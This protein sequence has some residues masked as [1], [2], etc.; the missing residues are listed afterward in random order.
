MQLCGAWY[1]YDVPQTSP[2]IDIL[3]IQTDREQRRRYTIIRE[4]S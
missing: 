3:D 2:V 1:L 4:N